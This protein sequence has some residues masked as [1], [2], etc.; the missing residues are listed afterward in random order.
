M[1]SRGEYLSK[2]IEEKG[3]NV[4]SLSKASGVAYTTIRSMIERDLANASIDNVLKIC[5]ILGIKAESLNKPELSAKEERDIAEDLARMIGELETNEA[6]AF[7]GEPMD[8]ETK[9]LMKISLENSL[10]LAKQVAKKKFN[11]NK[12]K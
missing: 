8:D 7:H 10:R 9:E 5:A 6:L 1:L 12:N 2:I 11:P 4:M 3:F